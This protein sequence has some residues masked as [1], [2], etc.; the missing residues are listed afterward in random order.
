MIKQV[1]KKIFPIVFLK[2]A[3]YYYNTVK[4]KSIDLILFPE[5]KVDKLKFLTYRVSFPFRENKVDTNI[6]TNSAVRNYMQQWNSWTQDEFIFVYKSKITIEP[7]I[8]WGIIG[9]NK[10]LYYSLGISRTLFLPKPDA[11]T[12]FLGK[13]KSKEVDKIVSLR[14][15]GEENYFHFF[16]D[17][18]AK[19]YFLEL[20]GIPIQEYQLLIAEKT[21]NK[22][23]F[24][25]WLAHI[26][27]ERKFTW[28]VQKSDEY[29][30]SQESIFCKP[31][32]HHQQVLHN[33]FQPYFEI[34]VENKQ[35]SEKIYLKR[36]PK[37]LRF[38]EN[39]EE[40]ENLVKQHGFEVVDTD[41]LVVAEQIALFRGVKK[42][43]GV[44]GAGLTNLLFCAKCEELIELFP[45]P[46]AGY[47]PFHYILVASHKHIRYN[48]VIGNPTRSTFSGSFLVNEKELESM[49]INRY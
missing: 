16:N 47:L 36:N 6:I 14:D 38:V 44:H 23:F 25:F 30:I 42:V 45:P 17:V 18:L 20:Q 12:W 7:K 11:F 1:L 39:G 5:F 22:S 40:I 3:F 9:R 43:I 34:S 33:L 31:I 13:K 15:T 27:R 19:I 10:L 24:Q 26:G 32:T 37:R 48:A 8:G 49:I 21:W 29:I 35:Y 2:K 28:L 41:E 4:I 46:D